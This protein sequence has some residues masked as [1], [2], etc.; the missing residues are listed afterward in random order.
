MVWHEPATTGRFRFRVTN[1]ATGLSDETDATVT[2]LATPTDLGASERCGTSARL[3]WRPV[4]GVSEYLVYRFD[5]DDMVPIG[6]TA[7]SDYSLADLPADTAVL[8]SVSAVDAHGAESVRARAV[9]VG[10]EPESCSKAVPVRWVSVELEETPLGI[11]VHWSVDSEYDCDY[12]EVQRA[13]A[14]GRLPTWTTVGS[15]GARG[16]TDTRSDYAHTDAGT[17]SEQQ[18]YYRIRQV[19]L[20]GTS[21]YSV[22]VVHDPRGTDVSKEAVTLS[23][24]SPNALNISVAVLG[25]AHAEFFDVAGRRLSTIALH[26]GANVVPWPS[27]ASTGAYVVRVVA[28]GRTY[29]FKAVRS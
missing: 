23:Q 10:E 9:F 29:A 12:Y 25:R 5:G 2:M 11:R 3:S 16:L 8:Y 6:T 26:P 28:G 4:E 1:E 17:P 20:D 22:V 19:D 15:V 27:E 13:S 7:E 21:D 24:N 18:S 14:L